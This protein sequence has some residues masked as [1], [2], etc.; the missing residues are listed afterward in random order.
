MS[1]REKHI[2]KNTNKVSTRKIVS[3]ARPIVT[4][5]DLEA[6]LWDLPVFLFG[7]YDKECPFCQSSDVHSN[8]P[9]SNP[10]GSHGTL[11]G[12]VSCQK[13][14]VITLSPS[15]SDALRHPADPYW[16]RVKKL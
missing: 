14:Y 4:R 2:A 6:E 13:K 11:Y 9:W 7:G 16:D 3:N 10:A 1:R 12:C 5:S 15:Y 8:G